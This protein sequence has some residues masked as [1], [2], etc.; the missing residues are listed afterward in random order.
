MHLVCG[1]L[2]FIGQSHTRLNWTE[3]S[4]KKRWTYFES[5]EMYDWAPCLIRSSMLNF[6]LVTIEAYIIVCYT[7]LQRGRIVSAYKYVL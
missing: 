2:L 7:N 5:G 3:F 6:S 4:G 1:I